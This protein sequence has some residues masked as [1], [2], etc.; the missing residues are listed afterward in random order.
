VDQTGLYGDLTVGGMLGSGSSNKGLRLN[1]RI[2]K[3]I[4]TK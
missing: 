4:R 3:Q 1:E 2:R